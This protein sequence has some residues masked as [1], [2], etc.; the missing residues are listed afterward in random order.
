MSVLFVVV[1]V[2]VMTVWTKW[3]HATEA[4]VGMVE[5]SLFNVRLIAAKS[6][7]IRFIGL[8]LNCLLENS[9]F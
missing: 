7:K 3:T 1:G 9:R 5:F 8:H 2:D 6:V 4:A